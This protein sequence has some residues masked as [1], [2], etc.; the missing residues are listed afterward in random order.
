[1]ASVRVE[2]ILG[3]IRVA[4]EWRDGEVSG[5]P[6]LLTGMKLQAGKGSHRFYDDPLA[7]AAAA[8]QMVERYSESPPRVTSEGID[9][10]LRDGMAGLAG[11]SAA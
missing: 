4:V 3:H 11:R 7:F 9:E 6:F 1:M 8:S 10:L 5:S 2:G